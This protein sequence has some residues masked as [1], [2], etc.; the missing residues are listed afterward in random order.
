M[1]DKK[2]L[3]LNN[4]ADAKRF[5]TE[6]LPEALPNKANVSLVILADGRELKIADMSDSEL[7]QY[8]WECLPIYKAAFPELVDT[9]YEH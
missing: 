2:S 8:A 1:G 9:Q 6:A 5:L 4:P 7:V 3:D